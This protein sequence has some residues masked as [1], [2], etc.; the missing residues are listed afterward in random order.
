MSEW[1]R[2]RVT[3]ANKLIFTTLTLCEEVVRQGGVHFIEHPRDPREHPF[4]SMYT[5]E[6]QASESWMGASRVIGDQ[7]PF[8]ACC[9]KQSEYSGTVSIIESIGLFC[10]GVSSDHHHEPLGTR[11]L[12]DGTFKSKNLARYPSLLCS[13]ISTCFDESFHFMLKH[14]GGSFGTR[15]RRNSGR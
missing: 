10:Q 6:L 7:C 5:S 15:N 8:G 9:R 11:L 2:R 13:A 14:G 4:H 1:E 12:E 3:S